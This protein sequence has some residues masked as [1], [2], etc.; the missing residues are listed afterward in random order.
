MASAAYIRGDPDGFSRW[1]RGKGY[2]YGCP[3]DKSGWIITNKKYDGIYV[4]DQSNSLNVT[5]G[6]NNSFRVEVNF[7]YQQNLTEFPPIPCEILDE[8][9]STL[10]NWQITAGINTG[11]MWVHTEDDPL[12]TKPLSTQIRVR[13][14][15]KTRKVIGHQYY[16]ANGYSEAIFE[17]EAELAT[18]SR[19]YVYIR[20]YFERDKFTF[21]VSFKKGT[22]GAGTEQ[23]VSVL[24]DDAGTKTLDAIFTRAGYEQD[25]WSTTDGGALKYGLDAEIG[26]VTSDV[27]LYPHW[28]ASTYIVTFN[29]NGG[30]TPSPK[31]KSVTFNSTYGELATCT[32]SGH[33]VFVGWHTAASGGTE[34][35]STT[36]V[37]RTADH[38]LYAH[39][40]QEYAVIFD[41]NGGQKPSEVMRNLYDGAV[42]GTLPT[43]VRDGY[44]FLGWYTQREGGDRIYATTVY[45]EAW[46]DRVYAQWSKNTIKVTF[47]AQGGATA[48]ESVT[49]EKDGVFGTLP[50]AIRNFDETF[51]GWFTAA[52]GGTQITPTTVVGESDV[53]IYAHYA[54]KKKY[55]TVYYHDLTGTYETVS[56]LM[57]SG[58]TARLKWI[59]SGLGWATP[60]GYRGESAR[61]WI[62]D[63]GR[64]YENGEQVLDI[65]PPGGEIHLFWNLTR[66]TYTITLDANGGTVSPASLTYQYD[67]CIGVLPTPTKGTER[68]AGWFTSATGGTEYSQLEKV[69]ANRTLYA[70]W[71]AKSVDWF[72]V[73][74]S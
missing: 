31:S 22:Y 54:A 52:S 6:L 33:Y 49:V 18:T 30:D 51:V 7:P 59:G 3:K 12:T 71:G 72:E 63:N 9:G 44:T 24:E 23:T 56:A 35:K 13:A 55:Y 14:S 61:S 26:A 46:G 39:W 50:N 62:D 70:H 11:Y 57:E 64:V 15:S 28:K 68:F 45:R 27:D 37:T 1:N 19:Y 66:R 58:V 21:T 2:Y 20:P 53:T 4:L 36:K 25:G 40:K 67:S 60:T 41:A 42:F 29:A 16:D 5:P 10:C 74:L 73:I 17:G 47:D 65:A 34:V 43:V 69:T 32:R 8:D 48:V 38:T